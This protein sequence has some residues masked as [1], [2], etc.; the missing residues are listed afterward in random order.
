MLE[1]VLSTLTLGLI[2]A[3]LSYGVYIT[4]KIL[5][6]PDLSVDGSFPLGAAVT[7]V[8]L[9]NGCDP[10]LTLLAAL[11]AGAV[12]GLATG[13]IHVKLKVRDLLAGIIVMTALFSINLQIAGSNLYVERSIN[14]IFTAPP[15]MA[16][17]GSMSLVT[18]KLVVSFIIALICKLLLDLYFKT[19]NG[20]LLRATGDNDLLVTSLAQDK[21]KMKILGLVISNALV[22]LCGCIVCHEQRS[23]SSTMGT[24]Q[25]VFGLAAVIIGTTLFK[26]SRFIKSTTAALIGSVIYK[27]CIQAAISLGLPANLLKLITALLFLIILVIGNFQKSAVKKNA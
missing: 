21:G 13:L 7:A 6:F 1:L 2:Y 24:G 16:L 17:F 10:Y 15:T 5:D 11:L 8:L 3:L 20:L 18:R 14:T 23:F 22:S 19:K 26:N 9:V 27:A 25:V 4:Y 12:A